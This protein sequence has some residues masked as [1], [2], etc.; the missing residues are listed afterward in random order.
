MVQLTAEETPETRIAVMVERVDHATFD[1]LCDD[2]TWPH[3]RMFQEI[4]NYWL[5][6][7]PKG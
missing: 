1:K 6:N 7:Q 5:A 3:W 4:L 2:R